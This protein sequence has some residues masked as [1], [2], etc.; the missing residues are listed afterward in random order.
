M[1]NEIYDIG[2]SPYNHGGFIPN[3]DNLY[4]K[5][6]LDLEQMFNYL[7]Q[8]YGYGWH[9][10]NL[11]IYDKPRELSEF[12]T[13]KKCN[14]CKWTGYES[15]A[16]IYDENCKRPFVITRPFQSWGYVYETDT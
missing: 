10:S 6:C 8:G 14:A 2:Y 15:A 3:T 4:E 13:I 1:C 12:H 9:I 11:V 5:S 7:S 16:C